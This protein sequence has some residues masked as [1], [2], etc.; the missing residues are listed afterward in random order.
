MNFGGGT[1]PPYLPTAQACLTAGTHT[2]SSHLFTWPWT[3]EGPLIALDLLEK[4][5]GRWW[6]DLVIFLISQSLTCSIIIIYLLYII[7]YHL[8]YYLCLNNILKISKVEDYMAVGTFGTAF[9]SF[10]TDSHEK[11]L[12]RRPLESSV[13]VGHTS[14]CASG[15]VPQ[16]SQVICFRTNFDNLRSL[17]KL[18]V[19]CWQF[20]FQAVWS[21]KR[22][23][24]FAGCALMVPCHD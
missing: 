2:W 7:I 4:V 19:R 1:A 21:M 8:L 17:P 23:F 5:S 24:S 14:P 6:V 15:E 9:A 10:S 18:M 12:S 13:K 11:H 16:K 20:L 3:W 22:V